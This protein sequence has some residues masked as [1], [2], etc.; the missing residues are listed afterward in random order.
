MIL[1]QVHYNLAKITATWNI[2]VGDCTSLGKDNSGRFLLRV[3]VAWR[4]QTMTSCTSERTASFWQHWQIRIWKLHTLYKFGIIPSY[5]W[6]DMRLV[7]E[8]FDPPTYKAHI[9]TNG[10]VVTGGSREKSPK[11]WGSFVH[12][13]VYDHF[14]QPKSDA[15]SVF[16][17]LIFTVWKE[18]N[19]ISG[20]K[21]SYELNSA[22][23][24]FRQT[25]CQCP[26]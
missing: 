6:G 19:F 8:L 23:L 1:H 14:Q 7:S 12:K 25:G 13:F 11:I 21:A 10:S 2:N 3:T 5:I 20:V 24:L 22:I 9:T 15:H 16:F 4:H 17:N 18:W 26:A